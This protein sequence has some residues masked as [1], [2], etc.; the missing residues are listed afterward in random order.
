MEAARLA[1]ADEVPLL[2]RLSRQARAELEPTRGGELWALLDA[3]EDPE[4]ALGEAIGRDDRLVLAGTIDDA[5]IGYAVAGLEKLPNGE[6]L[7]VLSDLY[8][9]PEARQVGVGE[10]LM[11]AALGWCREK[12]CRGLDSLALPGNRAAKNF[13]ES[14][15]LVARQILVHRSLDET[16]D[17]E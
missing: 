4:A 10:A 9:E 5:V 17:H 8:V 3:P 14:F 7:A 1:R 15:G 2:A 16:D 11:N 13:F 12:G 6:I